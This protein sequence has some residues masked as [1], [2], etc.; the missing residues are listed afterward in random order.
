MV[1]DVPSVFILPGA[2][3]VLRKRAD[4][5][6]YSISGS[7]LVTV[8]RS[9][10]DARDRYRG[11]DLRQL[12]ERAMQTIRGARIGLVFQEPLSRFREATLQLPGKVC[13]K[14]NN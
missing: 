13:V 12:D 2:I 3:C 6:G 8:A 11:Q 9:V 14:T 7:K 5:P 4:P 1:M 10:N